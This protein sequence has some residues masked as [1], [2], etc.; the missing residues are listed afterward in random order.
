MDKNMQNEVLIGKTKRNSLH[1]EYPLFIV[2]SAV[3]PLI[4]GLFIY[5]T[6]KDHTILTDFLSNIGISLSRFEYPT[7]IRYYA[8]DFLWAY[9]MCSGLWLFS[10]DRRS[11]KTMIRVVVTAIGFAA[12]FESLQLI[13]GFP[14]TFDIYDVLVEAAAIIIATIIIKTITRRYHYEES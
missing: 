14:G 12:V 13:K 9:A 7:I 2:F 6:S 1:Y 3:I 4:I 11:N 8:C 5:M 10:S